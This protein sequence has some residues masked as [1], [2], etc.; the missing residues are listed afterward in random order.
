M[1]VLLTLISLILISTSSLAAESTDLNQ[2]YQEE[3]VFL[4]NQLAALK[5]RKSKIEQKEVSR[6]NSLQADVSKEKSNLSKL[7]SKNEI[8]KEQISTFSKDLQ[9]KDQILDRVSAIESQMAESLGQI[10]D[11]EISPAEKINLHSENAL[12]K[13]NY[14]TGVV[15][16]Q[17]KFFNNK[18][19]ETSGKLIKLGGV[20]AYAKSE[21]GNWGLLDKIN[22]QKGFKITEKASLVEVPEFVKGSILPISF[23]S[24]NGQKAF[25]D[26]ESY[27]R[28]KLKAGGLI[29]IVILALGFFGFLVFL[30]R[31]KLLSNFKAQSPKDFEKSVKLVQL[32]KTDE[33]K[34]ILYNKKPD[35]WFNFL[36]LILSNRNKSDEV[37]EAMV[38]E[39]ISK[40]QKKVVKYGPVLLVIAGVAPLLGLLGTVTGMI[41][42]FE[43]ITEHGTGNPKLLSGGIKE[44]LVTTQLGLV[45]AIPCIL[46]GNWLSQWS[47]RIISE[48]EE[49]ASS[50]PKLKQ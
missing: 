14:Q 27:L 48:F 17:G 19:E 24:K 40:I 5:D 28:Q 25:V 23:F 43:M 33:A 30:I 31:F 4:K 12:E 8:L 46:A 3:Y 9:E 2:A 35:V 7:F 10:E 42:T 13:L 32:G 39:R 1:K 38:T 45:V 20:A 16:T 6:V 47:N 11:E 22:G 41:G 26:K 18:G 37:Y 36:D 29:G 34:E 15:E 44:A 49:V 21:K 50:I